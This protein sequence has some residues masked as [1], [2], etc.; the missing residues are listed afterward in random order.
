[1][2]ELRS[3]FASVQMKH[4]RDFDPE[5]RSLQTLLSGFLHG[6][7]ASRLRDVCAVSLDSYTTG[8][9]YVQAISVVQP[10]R[11]ESS[12]EHFCILASSLKKYS[13]PASLI[14]GLVTSCSYLLASIA[15]GLS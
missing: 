13:T 11:A 6:R 3:G 15:I 1:M 14:A 7:H 5:A 8:V 9:C 4:R 2:M 10:L 12:V